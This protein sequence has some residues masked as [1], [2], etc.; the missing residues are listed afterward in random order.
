[1]HIVP[2]GGN[3]LSPGDGYFEPLHQLGDTV[4]AGELAGYL[5]LLTEPALAPRE[6]RFAKGGTVYSQRTFGIVKQ[7]NNLCVLVE[8]EE[9]TAA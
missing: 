1:M 3:L 8:D 4:A 2:D 9:G 6:V 5:H 7:G